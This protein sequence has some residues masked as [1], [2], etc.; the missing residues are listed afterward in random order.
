MIRR[1]FFWQ[2]LVRNAIARVF[3]MSNQ[4]FDLIVIGGGIAG[5]GLA[6]VMQRAGFS[7]LV[8]EKDARFRDQTKGEWIAPWGVA[9]AARTGLLEPLASARGHVLRRHVRYDETVDAT[10][11][12]AT[13]LQLALLPDIDGPMT[14]RHPDACQALFDAA[15]A[16]GAVTLRG[17]SSIEVT[18]G[19]R[20]TVCYHH[21]NVAYEARAR[22]IVGADG[23]SSVARRAAGIT[24]H[25]AP[26]HHMFSGLLVDGADAWPDDLETAGTEGDLHFLAFPQGQGRVRLYLGFGLDQR[27]RFG[28]V[29]GPRKFIESF[30]FGCVPGCDIFAN[31]TPNGPCASYPNEDTWTDEPYA[32]GVVLIGDAAGWNDPIIGQGLAITMRDIRIVSELLTE[33]DDWSPAALRPYAEER[34]ERMRRLRFA[35]VL[36]SVLHNE[37]GP[38]ARER[39]VR[40]RQRMA[41][42]QV[43]GASLGSVMVG[44]E[45]VTAEAFTE[46]AWNRI[47]E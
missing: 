16:A 27:A 3:T 4:Q 26:P 41:E 17:V 6:T 33:T 38:E 31:A 24:L 18:S 36:Q 47:L 13:I 45:R 20:P 19:D 23:R 7:C 21:D 5:S 30:H 42:D 2:A 8:L 46:Q 25:R 1:P 22:L 35:G 14:Q 28:G 12:E 37:F 11:A 34:T 40:A 15:G 44:P 43:L 9:E 29:D 10:E 32:P 39:R